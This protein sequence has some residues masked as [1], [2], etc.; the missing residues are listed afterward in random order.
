M[1]VKSNHSK[2]HLTASMMPI[3]NLSMHMKTMTEQSYSMPFDPTIDR[4]V[5]RIFNIPGLLLYPNTKTCQ[6]R[7]H[8]G[9]TGCIRKEDLFQKTVLRR[10]KF[11]LES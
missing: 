2:S 10:S 7:N 5:R 4:K 8:Y 1:P 11:I 3:Y 6:R 9:D